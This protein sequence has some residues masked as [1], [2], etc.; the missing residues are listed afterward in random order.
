[1]AARLFFEGGVDRAAG[2]P[3]DLVREGENGLFWQP[4]KDRTL[5][6]TVQRLLDDPAMATSMSMSA[7]LRSTA[8][9]WRAAAERL[10]ATYRAVIDRS[11]VVCQ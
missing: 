5:T 11:Q 6:R 4:G 7:S 2:G 8:Y 10:L 3:L 9:T 1:M